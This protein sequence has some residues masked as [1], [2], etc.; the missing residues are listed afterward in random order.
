MVFCSGVEFT[1]IV[2]KCGAMPSVYSAVG[3][4]IEIGRNK[5]VVTTLMMS[6]VLS[7]DEQTFQRFGNFSNFWEEFRFRPN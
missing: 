3:R 2:G 6:I 1:V 7:R 5:M 4:V